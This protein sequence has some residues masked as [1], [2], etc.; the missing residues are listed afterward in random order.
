VG[1]V[2]VS[3][4]SAIS[5]LLDL[6]MYESPTAITKW[7]MKHPMCLETEIEVNIGHDHLSVVSFL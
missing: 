3:D 6:E 5:L 2:T 4:S 1:V 7:P